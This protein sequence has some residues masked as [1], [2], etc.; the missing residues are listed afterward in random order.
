MQT[1]QAN[2]YVVKNYQESAL[3]LDSWW[4]KPTRSMQRRM[5][6]ELKDPAGLIQAHIHV[7]DNVYPTSSPIREPRKDR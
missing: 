4:S 2:R 3:P 6:T 7:S 1:P 5:L